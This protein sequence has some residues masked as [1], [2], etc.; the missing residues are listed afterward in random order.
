MRQTLIR[1][2]SVVS[3]LSLS[4]ARFDETGAFLGYAGINLNVDGAR[5]PLEKAARA[6]RRQHFLL[7]LSDRLRDLS[8]P[9]LIMREVEAS[10]GAELEQAAYKGPRTLVFSVDRVEQR[11]P[12]VAAA[13]VDVGPKGE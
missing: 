5:E 13:A 11:R 6:E 3:A 1:L 7:N 8:D 2:D 9:G 4:N 12:A 10:I